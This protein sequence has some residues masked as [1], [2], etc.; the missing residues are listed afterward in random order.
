MKGNVLNEGMKNYKINFE[1]RDLKQWRLSKRSVQGY[2]FMKETFHGYIE[3][4][5]HLS[6]ISP[7]PQYVAWKKIIFSN[8]GISAFNDK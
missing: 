2:H 1:A 5:V 4:K 6:N 7:C 8:A 3:T